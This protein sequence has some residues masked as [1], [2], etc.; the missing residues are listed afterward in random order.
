MLHRV[1]FAAVTL[2]APALAQ[3]AFSSP[4]ASCPEAATCGTWNCAA[5]CTCYDKSVTYSCVQGLSTAQKC[6]CARPPIATPPVYAA[7]VAAA[8]P[9]LPAA[10]ELIAETT[11]TPQQLRGKRPSFGFTIESNPRKR[12]VWDAPTVK[13]W[14]D[15]PFA[16]HFGAATADVSSAV[17]AV[18]RAAA[19]DVRI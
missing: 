18:E 1:V 12:V 19:R 15:D 8:A 6:E 17:A 4:P 10:F 3:P 9:P 5:W 16:A 13:T 14:G 7:A 11:A 2:A